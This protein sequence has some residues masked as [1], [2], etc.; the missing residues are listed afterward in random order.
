MG[1]RAGIHIDRAAWRVI[2]AQPET[3]VERPAPASAFVFDQRS[4]WA[5]PVIL[6]DRFVGL[7]YGG[8]AVTYVPEL[9][10][11]RAA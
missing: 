11:G 6:L 9:A 10:A 2:A 5:E 8:H 7:A 1:H 4:A 3:A